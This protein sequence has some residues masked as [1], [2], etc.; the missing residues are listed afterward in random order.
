MTMT[1]NVRLCVVLTA[2]ADSSEI[3]AD[4]FWFFLFAHHGKCALECRSACVHRI[5]LIFG[6]YAHYRKYALISYVILPA[7]AG[8]SEISADFP[9]KQKRVCVLHWLHRTSSTSHAQLRHHW[10][11]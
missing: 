8:S 6:C 1:A 4:F 5:C 7:S 9:S 2:L 3:S 10:T 11:R